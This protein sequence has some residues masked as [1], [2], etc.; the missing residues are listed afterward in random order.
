MIHFNRGDGDR[1]GACWNQARE[2]APERPEPYVNLGLLALRRMHIDEAISMCQRAIDLDP[3]LVKAYEVL[4]SAAYFKG[5]RKA[6]LAYLEKAMAL[7]PKDER[8][9]RAARAMSGGPRARPGA[10]PRS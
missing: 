1:A 4:A 6:A 7:N 8:L 5:N 2:W 10:L 3:G 9:K